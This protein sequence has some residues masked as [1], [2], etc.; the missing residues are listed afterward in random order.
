[1]SKKTKI[2]III[3]TIIVNTVMHLDWSQAG[4]IRAKA[5]RALDE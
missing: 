1:V 2:M 3:T 4:I 5:R